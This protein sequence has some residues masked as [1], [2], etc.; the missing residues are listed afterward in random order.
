MANILNTA[1][2]GLLAHQRG[3]ATTTHN[4]A[5]VNTEGFSRQR[6]NFS[7]VEPNGI[8]RTAIGR[9]VELD[10]VTR[11]LS[12]FQ[13]NAVRENVTDLGRVSAFADIAN[14]VDRLLADVDNGVA[15]G[16][17]EF[18]NALQAVADDPSSLPARQ[19]LL[20]DA[21]SLADRVQSLDRR[22][23]NLER[24][25]AD[26]IR[27]T[28]AEINGLTETIAT[29]NLGIVNAGAGTGGSPNDLLD[30]RDLALRQ[31]SQLVSVNATET[32]AGA[33][34]VFLDDG[35]ALVIDTQSRE[36][37]V[38]PA[39]YGGVG[40]DVLVA[41]AGGNGVVANGISGGEIGGLLNTQAEVLDPA[42]SRL[43]RLMLGL[44]DAV[45]DL[46]RQGFDLEGNYGVNLFRTG[47]PEIIASQYNDG[48]VTA[49]VNVF[50]VAALPAG[51]YELTY[52]GAF[53]QM[54]SV[55]DGS[56]IALSGNGSAGNPLV[57]GGVSISL[58]ATPQAGDSFLIRPAHNA[59]SDFA[60][61]FDRPQQIAA[62]APLVV[63]TADLNSGTAAVSS[64]EITDF[65]DPNLLSGVTVVFLDA[66]TFQVNGSGA[67]AHAE[68][69]P[70]EL[71]GF[72]LFLS[73]TPAAGDTFT[74]DENV[75]GVGDNQNALAMA[76]SL[77]DPLL[78][79]GSL[80]VN[81]A[82]GDLAAFVANEARQANV[83]RDAQATI[84]DASIA[85]LEATSGVNLDEEATNMLRY[86][87]AYE[88][89][90]RMIAV[91]SG[92]FQTL[93]NAVGR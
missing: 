29:L 9:G 61:R 75:G 54:T 71:N 93:L 6:V 24:F 34:N 44:A 18:Y 64:F 4:I 20:G 58:S 88:A 41:D 48:G 92:L 57:G 3:L 52:N 72:R 16:L 87:Q 69:D 40:V 45:N 70:I 74:I 13:A 17:R 86:Q 63:E 35:Q 23:D 39:E 1:L 90:A 2:S 76:A 22:F 14:E 31:L 28:A 36:L 47:D 85:E 60:V 12:D 46:Q 8:G 79:G 80:S 89:S 77:D 82:F 65:N 53:Y 10:S 78:E 91:A 19:V 11:V 59:P 7:A 21:S 50:D 81:D 84:T 49:S 26:R 83:T 51:D 33:L 68:D 25:T 15:G 66:D 27:A 30:Q 67:F 5:N 42:R 38:A 37:S 62:A 43:G 32:S 56:N 55:A 73:G